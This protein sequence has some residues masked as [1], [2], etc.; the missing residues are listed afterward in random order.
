LDAY[1]YRKRMRSL[2]SGDICSSYAP[3]LN[4]AV[5]SNDAERFS[6]T[7]REMKE[8]VGSAGLEENV[9]RKRLRH[10]SE[11]SAYIL[12]CWEKIQNMWADGSIGS[13]TEAMVSH[14]FSERFSRNPMGWGKTGLGKM[15][16]IRVFTRN[17]GRIV[18][19]DLRTTAG[20][21]DPDVIRTYEGLVERQRKEL[22]DGMKNWRLTIK[23]Q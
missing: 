5:R 2:A 22:F 18:A 12:N 3:R 6:R 20:S 16:D 21:S 9:A 23:S 17:G 14:V 1:H 10:I 7:V 13:C 8:K 15:S 4:A 11:D 19:D